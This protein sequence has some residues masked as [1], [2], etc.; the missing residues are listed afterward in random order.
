MEN[1]PELIRDQMQDTRTALTEKLDTLGQKVAETVE[2]ITTPVTETVQ[3][4]KEAVSNTVETVK[5]TVSESVDSVKE[6]FN[7]AHQVEK[8]PWP[9]MLGS[10]AAGFVLGRLLPSPERVFRSVGA[11]IDRLAGTRAS[12]AR[13]Y[14]RTMRPA[15]PRPE[16][17]SEKKG[18]LFDHLTSV[19]EEE[20]DKLKGLGVS[21]GVGLLRDL[22][23]QSVQGEI[24][25][26]L[27]EWMDD[28]TEKLG[29]KPLSEP[30]VA[31][32]SQ[33]DRPAS[34]TVRRPADQDGPRPSAQD[35]WPVHETRPRW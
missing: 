5:D 18:G 4:V 16:P 20:L 33:E 11:E 13:D 32:Q 25:G 26:R 9:M 12:S 31:P 17:P 28:L 34:E 35:N 30:V 8:H 21:V 2:S 1:E 15:E 7:L 19:F 24:G 23:S 29:A 10:L 22:M 27:R 3:T 14:P 6:T